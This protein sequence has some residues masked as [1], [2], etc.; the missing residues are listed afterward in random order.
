[1]ENKVPEYKI[2]KVLF[3]I[4]DYKQEPE[5]LKL[6]NE[7]HIPFHLIFHGQGTASSQILDY[8][9]LG[10]TKKFVVIS[11]IPDYKISVILDILQSK[12][13]FNMAGRG[14]AFTIAITGISSILCKIIA[15]QEN[16]MDIKNVYEVNPMK[17]EQLYELI[18]T[19]VNQG[20]SDQVMD[21]AKEVGATGGTV[22]HARGLGS[23]EATKFLGISV[24][25]D[26]ELVLIIAKKEDKKSIM[27][28]VCKSNGLNSP[29][30]GIIFSLP[31]DEQIG[32]H[33]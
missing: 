31:V 16:Y 18:I 22:V 13:H 27:E 4:I 8:L 32:L 21:A 17:Q 28:N 24:Q 2:L 26:K 12:L 23:H 33:F 6:Y 19:I 25:E 29:G 14:I 11:I 7:Q 20:Y 5:L 1:M 3:T 9:G 30:K 10:D 15:E